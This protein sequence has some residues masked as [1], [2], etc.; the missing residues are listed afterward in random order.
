MEGDLG[1]AFNTW[2]KNHQSVD[3]GRYDAFC[4]GFSHGGIKINIKEIKQIISRKLIESENWIMEG[5]KSRE[6]FINELS[7]ELCK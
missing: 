2:V 6:R 4:A 3:Y 7:E 1:E 5:E